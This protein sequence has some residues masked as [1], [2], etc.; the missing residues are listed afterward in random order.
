[1]GVS[2][3]AG[4]NIYHNWAEAEQNKS[5]ALENIPNKPHRT[6]FQYAFLAVFAR[7]SRDLYCIELHTA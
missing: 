3:Q 6:R 7:I 2:C 5:E 1:M 4:E